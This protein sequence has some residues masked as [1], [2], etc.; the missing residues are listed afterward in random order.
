[1]QNKWV[2]VIK[3]AKKKIWYKNQP[4]NDR[5]DDEG[6]FCQRKVTHTFVNDLAVVQ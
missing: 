3:T 4:I 5:F 2:T 6:S 1:L